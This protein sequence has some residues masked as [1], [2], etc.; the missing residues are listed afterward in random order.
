G[1]KI[2]NKD[3]ADVT[4]SYILNPVQT[5]ITFIPRP[6]TVRADDAQKV[7]DGSPLSCDT[8]STE[9]LLSGHI[10]TATTQGEQTDARIKGVNSIVEGSV[11]ITT[12]DGVDVTHNYSVT[13]ESGTLEV[14]P[15]PFKITTGSAED[16]YDGTALTCD[17]YSAE[18]LLSGH[19]LGVVF[20]GS[21]T[22]VGKSA[23]TVANIKITAADGAD[24]TANYDIENIEYDLGTL[25]V[26]KRK[27]TIT[28]TDAQTVY[29]GTAKS[30]TAHTAQNL[31]AGHSTQ[32]HASVSLTEAGT[33]K[34]RVTVTVY[35]GVTD[36]TANY[37]ITYIDGYLTVSPRPITVTAGS[38]KEEYDGK[39]HTCEKF[40]VTSAADFALVSGHNLNAATQGAQ[41]EIGKSANRIVAGSISVTDANGNAVTGNYE[42][43]IA[44]GEI[45]VTARAITVKADDTDKIYDGTALTCATYTDKNNKLLSVHTLS[46]T[47][48][49]SQTNAG[50]SANSIATGSVKI[51][52]SG[53]EDVTANYYVTVEQGTLE[54]TPRPIKIAMG[55]ATKVYDGTPL[56][57]N[58]FTITSD[59]SPALVLSHEAKGVA[60]AQI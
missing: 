22:S 17:T 14:K 11:K 4:S 55:S 51:T 50:K 23:N 28:A 19:I 9:N 12:A 15:R 36:V 16:I 58:D 10:I 20:T 1:I 44:D 3:G 56:S 33:I 37:D 18:N 30:S 26:N 8:Y 53:G 54:V 25:A 32:G 59:Y 21:Q 52:A 2:I 27:L 45:E 24:V 40:E 42:I 57:C 38:L 31:V 43:S 49:G 13:T 41:T 6:V 35:S 29:D 39:A 7:Y 5:Q 48:Q 47:T 34:N 46:A 60:V